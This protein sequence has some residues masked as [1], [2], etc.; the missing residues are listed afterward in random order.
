VFGQG[1]GLPAALAVAVAVAVAV[2]RER[3]VAVARG[4][5][6]AVARR[7]SNFTCRISS[8]GFPFLVLDNSRTRLTRRIGAFTDLGGR[9]RPLG[10]TFQLG[11]T[12]SHLHLQRT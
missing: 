11:G 1:N 8:F 10:P 7:R 4:R 12:R 5:S 2:A 9:S 3:S 6:V